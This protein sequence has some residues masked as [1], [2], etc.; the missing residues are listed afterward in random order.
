MS[1]LWPNRRRRDEELDE[2]I[3]SHLEMSI[4]DRIARGESP[5][6]AARSARREF[7]D[8]TT[9]REVTSDMWSGQSVERLIQ[10]IRWAVRGLLRSPAFTL[11]AVVTLALGIGANSA[12]F[13]VLNGVLLE[14]LAFPHPEQLVYI[15][16]QFP[17]LGFDQFPVDAAEFLEFR[18]R[19]RSFQD[20][21]AYVT[22]SVNIGGDG[23]QP[24]RVTAGIA[25]AS[26]F[27]TLAVPPEYGRTFT[28]E[29]TLPNASPVAVLSEELWTSNFGADRAVIGKQIDVNGTKTTVVGVMPHGFDVHDQGVEIWLPLT[30]DPAQRQQYRGGHF[31]FLIG[32]LAPNVTLPRA[33]AELQSLLAQWQVADGGNPQAK[34]GAP[35]FVHTPT[36]TTHRLRYDDLQKDMVGSIGTALLVL[37]C[38]VGLVLL[39]A[40]ANMANLL[41]MRAETRHRELAVRSALGAG[42]F[43]LMR[44]FV[45]ESLVLAFAGAAGGLA[46]AYWGLH[47][48][49]ATNAGS[50]PRAA[51]VSLDARVLLFTVLLALVTGLVFGLAPL[52][53]LST[54]S[55]GLT[56]RDAGSR[57]TAGSARSRVRRGLVIAE[58]AFA[59]M[60]VIGAGLLLR[61]FWNLM[62]VD[63]GFDRA[64]LTTFSI[65][66]PTAT[67][68]D[69]TRRVAFFDNLTHQL[70]GI[71]GVSSA[72]AMSGLPPRRTVNANDTNFEGYVPT[73]DSPP[74]NVDYYQYVT[75]GYVETMRI[76]V[77]SGRAFGPSDGPTSTPV[78]M[79]N[80]TLARTFYPGTNPIGRRLAPGN[81]KIFFTIV[82]VLKDVKQG[83]V[84]SKTG[85]ELYLD[86]D[87][88]PATQGFA[89]TNMNVVMRSALEPASLAPT[90]RRLVSSLDPTLPIVKYRSMDEVFSDSV[91][92][93][94]FLAQL[95]GIFAVVALALAAIGTYG[96]LAY[97]VAARRR[98]LG[99]RM[100]LG[101]SSRGLLSLVLGQGMTLAAIG[102]A[103]GMLGAVGVTRLAS[104]LLFGVKPVD[105]LTFG[106]VAA[107]MLLIAFLACLLP[108]RRATTVDPLVA[109]REE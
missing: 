58:M 102:L 10:D 25:S 104:S 68:R 3:R 56:L 40:C 11:L 30:L 2:E 20:V 43:R 92:R 93:Q 73:A 63:P 91:S 101:S 42:R 62:R 8:V 99:I 13:S 90:V 47:A 50:I 72:A 95:L 89:P 38:A 109:L 74:A 107:F 23:Q 103:V 49:V 31:L 106:A 46:L 108:A 105:P 84:D 98:E 44:Q 54:S 100:A 41:L 36:P 71:P 66:L 96:V 18:E 75:P 83:G 37:Q 69:S 27:K 22:S 4:R 7:G 17:K 64:K 81:S 1:A 60:L 26:L 14:P 15:T 61:S 70:A 86:Y 5:E 82:G 6:E 39:I 12:I 76:P 80:Q 79:I 24:A 78:V 29:E 9:V 59:V 34:P 77:V 35:G 67:Y 88:A 87:Q 48:L 52:L 33:K 85:T 53:H 16:S 51:S 32:R 21:G 55:I 28:M 94:R 65:A 45:A 57:T 19:N 97:S